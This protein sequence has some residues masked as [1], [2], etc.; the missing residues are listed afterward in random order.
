MAV[1]QQKNLF[2]INASWT[3]CSLGIWTLAS[4]CLSY[5]TLQEVKCLHLLK[6]FSPKHFE[7]MMKKA[8]RGHISDLLLELSFEHQIYEMV[9]AEGDRGLSFNE[10]LDIFLYEYRN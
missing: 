1:L 5:A 8:K 9:D 4:N 7:T 10:V 2:C 6:G 3:I